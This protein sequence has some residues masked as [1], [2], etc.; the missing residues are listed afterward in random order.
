MDFGPLVPVAKRGKT[1]SVAVWTNNKANLVALYLRHFCFVTKHGTY[2]DGFAGPQQRGEEEMWAAKLVLDN[3]PPRIRF[4]HLYDIGASQIAALECMKKDNLRDLRQRDPKMKRNIRV[5]RGDFNQ[6][7]LEMV[8][9]GTI[10]P[11]QATFCLLDQRTFEC[12]WATVEALAKCRKRGNKVELFYFLPVGWLHRAVAGL[13]DPEVEMSRWWGKSDWRILLDKH[14][15]DLARL[16]CE[17]FKQLDYK[18]VDFYPIRDKMEKGRVMY[19][20]IHATD[21][22]A[23]PELMNRAYRSIMRSKPA[24]QLE[25]VMELKE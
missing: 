3:E 2:I 25:L 8:R 4:A 11:R 22:S 16:F 1:P 15:I 13:N 7:V 10:R 6:E 17:R 9:L 14:H 20:M 5:T 21:H 12:H 24:V 23:A 18:F 19:Y